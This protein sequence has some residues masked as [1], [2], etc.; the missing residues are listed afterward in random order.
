MFLKNGQHCLQWRTFQ[1]KHEVSAEIMF[2]KNT[3]PSRQRQAIEAMQGYVPI[4]I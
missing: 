3:A 4:I 1:T 2:L